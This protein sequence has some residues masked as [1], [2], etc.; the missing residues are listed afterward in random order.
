M[1]NRKSTADCVTQATDLYSRV[2]PLRGLWVTRSASTLHWWRQWT[3]TTSEKEL[4][5]STNIAECIWIALMASFNVM[6]IRHHV[7]FQY[8]NQVM[9]SFVSLLCSSS[10]FIIDISYQPERKNMNDNNIYKNQFI[11]SYEY[12]GDENRYDRRLRQNF[13]QSMKR[14]C[15]R[16]KNQLQ[17]EP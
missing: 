12:H 15:R 17:M 5:L 4:D 6:G 10:V 3:K 14:V 7:Y 1:V 16:G 11:L 13:T 9:T 2:T 8:S